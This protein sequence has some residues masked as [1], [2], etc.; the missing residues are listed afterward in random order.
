MTGVQ[1]CA[2]PISEIEKNKEWKRVFDTSNT[3]EMAVDGKKYEL[4]PRS[5]AVFENV[6]VKK[7]AGTSGKKKIPAKGHKNA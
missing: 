2:L 5:I 7:T 1:T 4:A 3:M 6:P